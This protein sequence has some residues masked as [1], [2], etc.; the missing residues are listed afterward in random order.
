MK[1]PQ[2]EEDNL[3]DE[4]RAALRRRRPHT[5]DE[6]TAD[7]TDSTRI[8]RIARRKTAHITLQRSLPVAGRGDS[9]E[10]RTDRRDSVAWPMWPGQCQWSLVSNSRKFD[11]LDIG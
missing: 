2:E 1:I 3:D 8:P 4:I 11:A 6:K 7:V 5:A 10:A 9:G